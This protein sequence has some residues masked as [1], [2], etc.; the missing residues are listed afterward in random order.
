MNQ[1]VTLDMSWFH[2][3]NMWA[4]QWPLLD[5]FMIIM[6]KFG[7]VLLVM[8]AVLLCF[9]GSTPEQL[10]KN[11]ITSVVAVLAA[12]LALVFNGVI[13]EFIYRNRPFIDCTVNL[14]VYHDATNSFPSNHAAG[15]LAMAMVIYFRRYWGGRFM[16]ALALLICFSRVF[17]GVHYPL[18][19]LAGIVV[20][21]VSASI[22]MEVATGPINMIWHNLKN[23]IE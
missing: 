12:I 11:R 16:M 1:L 17:V 18:D 9:R 7:V 14:L 5:L 13:G 4:G 8:Y 21:I 22:M 19:V 6:T 15:S 23:R 20:G 10:Y 3:V 2:Y